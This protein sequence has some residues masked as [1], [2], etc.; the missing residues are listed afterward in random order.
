M[1]TCRVIPCLDMDNGLVVKGIRFENLRQAGDPVALA[2]RYYEQ[3]ADEIVFLDVGASRQNRQ[4]ML[5]VVRRVSR[6]VF[7]PL[8]VGG[9]IR[10]CDDIRACLLAGADKVSICTAAVENPTL[11]SAA[12]AR[13]GSQCLVLSIDAKRCGASWQVCTHG[14]SRLTAISALD[15]ARE[16]QR[17]GAGEILLNSIDQD[18]TGAGYDLSLLRAIRAQ[19]D[20]PLIASGGAGNS[21]Q[22]IA[23]VAEGGADAVLLASL[24][25][26]GHCTIVDVKKFLRAGGVAIR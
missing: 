11:I 1:L 8:T 10:S 14:G 16:A 4:T 3:G 15:W 12:A 7:V 25:H 5:D 22:L 24:L 19:V 17:L 26:F 9:G 2:C 23:A 18:G 21:Q 13:F 6:V 20:I